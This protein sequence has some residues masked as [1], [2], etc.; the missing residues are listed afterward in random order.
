M[1]SDVRRVRAV[2]AVTL[3]E[4][5][6]CRELPASEL[7]V[8]HASVDRVA[9]WAAPCA[10][11]AARVQALVGV[12][13]VVRQGSLERL[14]LGRGAAPFAPCCRDEK[15]R[16]VQQFQLLVVDDLIIRGN[17]GSATESVCGRQQK[18]RTCRA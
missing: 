2:K 14:A 18:A 1:Q 17:V 13:S 5:A 16:D 3:L 6:A 8:R 11:N 9:G 10:A 15:N 12:H 4:L 7:V